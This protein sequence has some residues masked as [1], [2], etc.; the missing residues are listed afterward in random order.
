MNIF[1]Q[2]IVFFF[3]FSGLMFFLYEVLR[4]RKK[5]SIYGLTTYLFFLGSFVWG[6][7]IILGPFWF[8]ASLISLLLN[9]WYLFLLITSIF[10]S[11]RSLGEIIYWLNEQFAPKNRNNPDTLRLYRFVKNDSVWFIYQLFWQCIFVFSLVFSIYCAKMWL[12][13]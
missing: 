9:N 6:D 1:E 2:L 10:W 3:G 8:I 11:I 7:L 12:A 13:R 4:L 5:K